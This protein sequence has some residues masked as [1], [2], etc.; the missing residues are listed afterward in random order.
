MTE[1]T[2]MELVRKY[3]RSQDEVAFAELV[4]RLLNLVFSVA[5]RYTGQNEDARDIAQAVFIVLARKARTLRDQTVLTGWLY[6]TTRFTAAHWQRTQVRRQAREQDAFMQSLESDSAAVW[7]QLSPHLEAAMSKLAERDRTLLALRFYENRSGPEAAAMLGIKEEAAHKRTARAL[8]KLRKYFGRKGIALSATAIAGA[9]SA[10]AVQTA[11]VGLAAAITSAALSGTTFTTAAMIAAT[12]SITMTTIQKITLTAALTI[13]VGVGIYQAN[14]AAKARGEAHRLQQ[15]LAPLTEQIQQLQ[16]KLDDATRRL[17]GMADELAQ[18]KSNDLEL[19]RLRSQVG[20]LR[21]QQENQ[22]TLSQVV[23]RTDSTNIV[24]AEDEFI[25][26]QTHAVDA[27]T[28][29]LNVFKNFA[30]GHDGKHPESFDQLIAS[31]DLQTTN[32]AG[33]L[34]LGDFEI[35][36]D[37]TVDPQGGKAVLEL[38]VPIQQPGG[39]R[40][41]VLGGITD[42]GLVHTSVV[43]IDSGP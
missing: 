9:V 11:P 1:M 3:A 20:V 35:V 26:Q 24:S 42:D 25:L 10:N 17:A 41:T 37:G 22:K 33:N 38:R 12:K 32:F 21:Q 4:H 27:M 13:S 28:T 43:N 34:G 16:S 29:L 18:A 31:G 8:E 39:R 2:D 6:E 23:A 14:E 7:Q 36:K 19:L 30:V 5:C 15:Q 40:A